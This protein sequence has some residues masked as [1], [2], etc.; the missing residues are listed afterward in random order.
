MRKF[1]YVTGELTEVQRYINV[2]MRWCEQYPSRERREFWI[3][4]DSG[5]DVKLT[6]HSRVMPARRGHRVNVLTLGDM[7]VGLANLTT[8]RQVNFV[9]ADPPLLVRRCDGLAAWGILGGGIAVA[10]AWDE[11]SLLFAVP[12]VLLYLPLL[13]LGRFLM[14]GRL[15]MQVDSWLATVDVPAAGQAVLRRVK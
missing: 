9:R 14:R 13:A 7:V 3:A 4:A 1:L 6:V 5:N 2:P 12:A 10:V 15:W 11:R 8:G